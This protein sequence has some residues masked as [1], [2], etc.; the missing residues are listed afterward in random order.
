ME[1]TPKRIKTGSNHNGSS[2]KL[3]KD[4][5]A[6]SLPDPFKFPENYSPLVSSGLSS[7]NMIPHTVEKFITEIARAAFTF[8]YYPLPEEFSRLA[9]QCV[10]KYPFLAS[11]AGGH[12]IL[13]VNNLWFLYFG[14]GTHRGRN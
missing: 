9:Q 8:K 3:L 7:E 12:V 13:A 14:A 2:F 1:S 10:Q 11:T 4:K 5:Y 6:K